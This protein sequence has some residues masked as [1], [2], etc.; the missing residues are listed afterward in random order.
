MELQNN[1]LLAKVSYMFFVPTG[2]TAAAMDILSRDVGVMTAPEDSPVMADIFTATDFLYGGGLRFPCKRFLFGEYDITA[3]DCEAKDGYV[4]ATVFED[5]GICEVTVNFTVSATDTEALVYLRQIFMSGIKVCGDKSIKELAGDV[6]TKL[7]LDIE[8]AQTSYIVELNE[9]FGSD[10]ADEV[11]S[12]SAAEL[13][14]IM[15]GD[16]GYEF[17][18]KELCQRRLENRWSTRDFVDAIVYRNNFLLVNIN[19][20]ARVQRYKEHQRQYGTEFYGGV[21]EYFLM[22]CAIAG[23]N[24]GIMFS[25]E[26][27]MVA[28]TIAAVVLK[29]QAELNEHHGKV[30]SSIAVTKNM[31]R[32]LILTL[33]R[34]ETIGLAELG[35]LDRLVIDGLDV[36]PLMEKIKYLL[37]LL[38]SELDLLYQTSTNRLVNFLTILGLVFAAIQI[39]LPFFSL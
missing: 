31:R 39:I 38:E 12:E 7:G 36:D 23:V 8:E 14:G 30:R 18:P 34:L 1:K 21:N 33:N 24:H 32:E 4:L 15:T 20:G 26:F 25:C 17:V 37:E 28:K 6:F 13:Y 9:F 19:H 27:G 22:D 3:R 35:D 10:N 5:A 16:E 11:V 29:K 2:N